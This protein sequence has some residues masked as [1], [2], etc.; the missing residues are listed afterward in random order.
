[1]QSLFN[2]FFKNITM[3]ALSAK[4][5]L[6]EDIRFVLSNR[7]PHHLANRFFGWFSRTDTFGVVQLEAPACGVPVAAYPITGPRDVIGSNPVGALDEDL[8][9][10]CLEALTIS[11]AACRAFAVTQSW[12]RSALQF[13]SHCQPCRHLAA[14]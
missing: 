8:K 3:R 13:I 11:R 1:M 9:S 12:E 4:T 2:D 5:P 14:A 6:S 10:A 7:I